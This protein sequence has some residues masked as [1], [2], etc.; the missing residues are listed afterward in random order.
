V[1]QRHEFRAHLSQGADRMRGLFITAIGTGIGKTL[2]TAILCR[3]LTRAGRSVRAIKPVVS[4][5]TP[6]DLSSDPS[7]LLRALDHAP[8]PE[9]IAAMAPWRFV[10]PLAPHLAARREGRTLSLD[11]VAAFCRAQEHDASDCL[12]IE[13]AGGVMTPIDDEHTFLDLI[14]RLGHPAVLVGGSYLGAISHMLTAIEAIRHRAVSIAG[15]VVS[16]ST[17][18]SGLDDTVE[19]LRQFTGG[20][21]DVYALPRLAGEDEEKW[22]K[23]P[24]LTGLCRLSETGVMFA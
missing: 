13:G 11:D 20:T 5:Y 15:I 9:M 23:A 7:V 2:V 8:A 18:S 21:T 24:L 3:Q 6:D 1:S 22:R 19:A 17:E 10:R 14:A 16:E 12:L 4:G